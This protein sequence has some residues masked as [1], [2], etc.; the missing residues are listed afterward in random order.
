MEIEIIF[1]YLQ[2]SLRTT[3]QV[4]QTAGAFPVLRAAP[5]LLATN[6]TGLK[7]IGIQR[8]FDQA[9]RDG[10]FAR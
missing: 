1:F 4:E 8:H 6:P 3:L 10:D 7:T 5:L 9:A 2:L